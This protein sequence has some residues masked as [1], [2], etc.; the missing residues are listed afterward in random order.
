MF[1]RPGYQVL[2]LRFS[3]PR[4]FQ[5]FDPGSLLRR[6]EVLGHVAGLGRKVR[7]SSVY[8]VLPDCVLWGL[9]GHGLCI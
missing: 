5:A 9:S 1:H 7:M 4:N 3:F 6:A 8:L 2:T